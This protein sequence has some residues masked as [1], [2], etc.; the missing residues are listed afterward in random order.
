MNYRHAFHAGNFADVFKHLI[1]TLILKHLC[2]KSKPLRYV[3]THGGLGVHMLTGDEAQRT[4]E[5]E[6]GI[7]RL[8]AALNTV[9]V[10]EAN[11][12]ALLDGYL[13]VLR[14]LNPSQ[15]SARPTVYPGSA[16]I[17]ASLL[18]SDDRLSLCELHLDDFQVLA[19]HFRRDQRV[20]VENRD[21]YAALKAYLPPPERRGLVLVDPPFERVDEFERLTSA[22]RQAYKRWSTGVYAL[23]YPIKDVGGADAFHAA[24]EAA[25]IPRILC[26]ELILSPPR[27]GAPLSATGMAIINP[28]WRLT[29]QLDVLL[30]FLVD[31]L[32]SD[33]SQASWRNL[34]LVGEER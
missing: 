17:A 22:L 10:G 4:K 15:K 31:N 25:G 3:D 12:A 5:A 11:P 13:S 29:E 28:P 21:G 32:A 16:Q 1:L 8:M 20:K 34:W 24:L 33:T 18:R 30:P 14:A 7:V 6:G 9:Q 23:W 26:A 19:R 2:E 27:K